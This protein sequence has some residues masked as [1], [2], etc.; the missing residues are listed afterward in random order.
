[1]NELSEQAMQDLINLTLDRVS[2]AIQSTTQLIHDESQQIQV[3]M[4]ITQLCF[5]AIVAATT[6]C[7]DGRGKP[8]G[9]KRALQ[10]NLKALGAPNLKEITEMG[11]GFLQQ[12]CAPIE[13]CI[14][15]EIRHPNDIN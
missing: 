4:A 9:D 3:L 7:V 14:V 10:S 13:P 5:Y 8:L 2:S 1:M 6:E 15:H 12:L 11:E